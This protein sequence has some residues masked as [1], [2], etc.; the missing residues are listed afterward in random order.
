MNS[1]G[2]YQNGYPHIGRSEGEARSNGDN[3]RMNSYGGSVG[4]ERGRRPGVY[5]GFYSDESQR[6]RTPPSRDSEQV[7][8]KTDGGRPLH[9]SSR[10]RPRDTETG[11][12]WRPGRDDT[13]YNV[14][15]GARGEGANGARGTQSIEGTHYIDRLS[16]LRVDWLFTCHAGLC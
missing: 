5:G 7:G 13:D 9:P 11:T 6:R 10:A 14:R 8:D 15:H 16:C 4:R 1:R 3:T 2:P 12:R